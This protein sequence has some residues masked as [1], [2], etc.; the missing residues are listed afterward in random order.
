MSMVDTHL[1]SSSKNF[2]GFNDSLTDTGSQSKETSESVDDLVDS[3]KKTAPA[4]DNATES[5]NGFNTT[6]RNTHKQ[7]KILGKGLGVLGTAAGVFGGLMGFNVALNIQQVTSASINADANIKKMANGMKWSSQQTQAYI[8][9]M[10]QL[11]DVYKKIDM[12]SVASETA[13]IARMYK[14][15]AT[16][17][18][19]AIEPVAVL[20]D[21]FV[22]E[23]RTPTDASL[24]VKDLVDQGPG[25]Q[26]R[27]GEVG[28]TQQNLTSA[29]WSGDKN[30]KSGLL[31]ALAKVEQQRSLTNM[32]KEVKTLDDAFNIINITAGQFLADIII[33]LTPAIVSIAFGFSSMVGEIKAGI[34]AAQ[35]FWGSLPT[36]MHILLIGGAIALLG[37][38]IATM[39]V[40]KLLLSSGSFVSYVVTLGLAEAGTLTFAGA[41]RV[42]AIAFL[43]NPITLIIAGVVLLTAAIYQAGTIMGWWNDLGGMAGVIWG[44]LTGIIGTLW[45][46][47]SGF[48]NW[49]GGVA[50]NVWNALTS[51]F[52]GSDGKFLG[53]VQ[54]FQNLGGMIWTAIQPG[55]YG[56]P[57]QLWGFFTS[58][59]G[60]IT[61]VLTA[62]SNANASIAGAIVGWFTSIDWMGVLESGLTALVS[63]NPI[64]LITRLL[65]GDA[66]ADTAI[67]TAVGSIMG[68]ISSVGG[69]ISG[70]YNA[71]AP[72]AGSIVSALQ[73]IICI[74]LGCSP[75][76]VPALQSLYTWFTGIFGSIWSFLGPIAGMITNGLRGIWGAL[77]QGDFLGAFVAGFSALSNIGSYVL[78]FIMGVDWSGILM[79]AFTA[80]AG[81]AA[82]YNP[83]AMIASLIFGP[84]AGAGISTFIFTT[85]MSIGTTFVTGL[86]VVWTGLSTMVAYVGTIWNTLILGTQLAWGLLQI[87][88]LNPARAIW[89]TLNTIWSSIFSIVNGVWT[90]LHSGAVSTFNAIKSAIMNPFNTV[91]SLLTTVW[92]GLKSGWN[93]LV[94]TMGSGASLLKNLVLSPIRTVYNALVDLWNLVTGSKVAKMAGGNAG[95]SPKPKGSAGPSPR[96]S[97]R[98]LFAGPS[99]RSSNRGLFAGIY[100]NVSGFVNRTANNNGLPGRY[101]GSAG[102]GDGPRDSDN[103]TPDDPCYA[104]GWGDFTNIKNKAMSALNTWPSKMKI[105]GLDI[106]SGIINDMKDGNLGLSTFEA[107]AR[108]IIGKTSYQY[109]YDG[110]KTDAQVISSGRCNCWD[111]AEVLIHLAQRMGL[112]ASMQ[113]G[114]WG[115]DGHV[116]ALIAGK[117]F[118]TTAFQHG[119]GWK[120]PKVKGYS[121][122]GPRPRSHAGSAQTIEKHEYNFDMTGSVIHGIDDL[123]RQMENVANRVFTK[124]NTRNRATGN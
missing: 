90:R 4:I 58:L 51:S 21:A 114:T 123:E 40:P 106:T 42:L 77:S 92:N 46:T 121:G 101:A 72:V 81:F 36:T 31:E 53:L 38:I 85:L 16:E 20:T 3:V 97:N 45:S 22:R 108:A 65:F 107:L 70:L 87:Y 26:R 71:V 84:S 109:Y 18:A 52:Y 29:G 9:K 6:L 75:G 122:A 13:T 10:K 115:A 117:I 48:I 104:G 63:I 12:R 1:S 17:A 78:N 67:S 99:P 100:N 11:Q 88:V 82:Q 95:P 116:W 64:T 25:W 96:S 24:A 49:V 105:P 14:L 91:K 89:T 93:T 86:Q 79:S 112:P 50:T 74:I 113:R 33:P 59:P 55:L 111:G 110:K 80:I 57:G 118:D 27:L 28:V 69:F 8:S 120:S 119:Y 2:G 62:Q 61:S 34:G 124:R 7:S 37:G 66:A 54:G 56:L 103:C 39:L 32:A 83:V 94:S 68:F 98:G 60:I 102:L 44:G 41:V 23:G 43:T 47:L 73:P 35:S 76:I 5:T 30:D 19:A 15:T